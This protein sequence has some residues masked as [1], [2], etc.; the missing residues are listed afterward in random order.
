MKHPES[1]TVSP[2]RPRWRQGASWLLSALALLTP[3]MRAQ[4]APTASPPFHLCILDQAVLLQRSQVAIREAARFQQLRQQAQGRLDTDRTA[5][6]TDDR[7]LA[8][9]RPGMAPN[10]YAAR[11][12]QLDARRQDLTARAGQLNTYLTQLDTELT[13][14][15]MRAATITIA[16]VEIAQGCSVLAA[17][18]SFLA[19][20]D[21]TL[22]ISDEVVRRMNAADPA[23][24]R[25]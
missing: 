17:K 23:Q 14:N 4:A 20:N 9:A 22:D 15:V 10:A 19:V 18:S 1:S 11:K 12:A 3:A 7:A 21:L 2:T 16:Q 13:N 8:L 6:E 24:K 5:L 25:P